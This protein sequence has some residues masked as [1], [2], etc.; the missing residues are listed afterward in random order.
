MAAASNHKRSTPPSPKEYH[1]GICGR[2]L[3]ALKH[4]IRIRDGPRSG[5]PSEA[6]RSRLIVVV[7]STLLNINMTTN[8]QK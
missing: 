6:C 3:T 8:V 7:C 4:Y 1:C 5:R 2:I